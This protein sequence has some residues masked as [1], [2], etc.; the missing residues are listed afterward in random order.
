MPAFAQAVQFAA[1]AGA[2][3]SRRNKSRKVP[4]ARWPTAARIAYLR[5]ILQLLDKVQARVRREL[6]PLLP[7]ILGSHNATRPDGGVGRID[8]TGGITDDSVKKI[9]AELEREIP[10]RDIQL[11]AQQSALRTAEHSRRELERQVRA[12][13]KIDLH[14]GE[15]GLATHIDAFI[16]DNVR[17]VK[18]VAFDQLGE[19]EGIILRGA[20]Q[21]LRHEVVAKQIEERFGVSRRRAALIARDQIGKLNG[22]IAQLRQQQLGIKRYHWSTS[23]DERVRASHRRLEG[24]VQQWSKPPVVDG[25]KIHPGQAVQC[26]CQAIPIIDDLL[27]EA[28]LL[29][30][31]DAEVPISTPKRPRSVPARPRSLPP[32]AV[33]EPFRAKSPGAPPAAPP[34]APPAA[35]PAP[36]ASPPPAPPKRR[37]LAPDEPLSVT[38]V[39]RRLKGYGLKVEGDVEATCRQVF[40]R[41]LTGRELRALFARDALG[42]KL[43]GKV[44]FEGLQLSFQVVIADEAGTVA[45]MGR[46]YTRD[47][48][49]G[50]SAYHDYLFLEPRAQAQGAGKRLVRAQVRAYRALGIQE[51]RLTCA[52]VGRYVW[53]KWGFDSPRAAERALIEMRAWLKTKSLAPEIADRAKTMNDIAKLRLIDGNSE[54]KIGKEFLLSRP[55][56]PKEELVLRLAE[57]DPGFEVFKTEVGL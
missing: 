56:N 7:T 40:G 3:R 47:R 34:P 50:A 30:P 19:L 18:S 26:R 16:A 5:G 24:T 25:E 2:V 45:R 12:V 33:P 20:R 38:A 42:G 22:E 1:A 28:G 53:P 35:P 55:Y 27:V 51:V 52:D 23:Q 11:L 15:Q 39:R 54:R 13:A 46:S 32:T 36:P 43:A 8:M 14:G 44:S 10:D 9:R 41:M 4:A 17:L 6:F 37:P 29:A 49:R 48:V 57:G 31:E 21:G